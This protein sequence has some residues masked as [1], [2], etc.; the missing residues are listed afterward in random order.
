MAVEESEHEKF[1][2]KFID[3]NNLPMLQN[4]DNKK[5]LFILKKKKKKETDKQETLHRK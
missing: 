1:L 5:K 2:K 4:S 3:L